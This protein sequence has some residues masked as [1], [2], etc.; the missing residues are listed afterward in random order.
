MWA[1]APTAGTSGAGSDHSQRRLVQRNGKA[2]RGRGRCGQRDSG[3]LDGDTPSVVKTFEVF[4][5]WGRLEVHRL[6]TGSG[7][8]TE[9]PSSVR[10]CD[11]WMEWDDAA[12]SGRHRKD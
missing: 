2:G 5:G 9:A 10:T 11:P 12:P 6:A 1:A 3:P 4:A 7:Q 8:R